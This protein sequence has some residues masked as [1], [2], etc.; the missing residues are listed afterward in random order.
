MSLQRDFFFRQ[1][2]IGF[3]DANGWYVV[4]MENGNG[5]NAEYIAPD[6][7]IQNFCLGCWY[8]SVPDALRAIA[9]Y[10]ERNKTFEGFFVPNLSEAD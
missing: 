8:E 3:S 5:L 1:F 4:D 7:T 6:G 9:N 2:H 10:A